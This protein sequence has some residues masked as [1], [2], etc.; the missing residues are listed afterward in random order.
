MTSP[1]SNNSQDV[2]NAF[3]VTHHRTAVV[4]GVK[5]FYREAGPADGETVVL[6][7]GFPTSSH[8]F[9]NLIPALADRYRVIAPDYPGYGQSD[10]PAHSDFAY[11]FDR[12]SLLVD[13]L[14]EQLGA[15]KYAMYVMD[16]GAP[17]GWRIAL[18]HPERV[19]GFI[20]QNGNAY[21]EGLKEFWDPIKQ[22]WNDE[23]DTSRQ[24]LQK[25]L[26]L[27]TTIFQ[28]T[29]GVSD[30]T[31]VAPDNWIHDQALL[32]R[33]GNNDIQLDLFFDYRTNLPLYPTVQAYFREHRP[34]MLIVWGKNDFIFPADGAH[35][36]KRDLPD[37]EFHLIDTGHFALEDKADE[38]IPLIRDFLA[39]KVEQR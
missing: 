3:A 32:D 2:N 18:K 16:Y 22:Y 38:M 25:L 36:Y 14:L 31:R 10:M 4:D 7:H 8:M 33:P 21:E 5:L 15:E 23:S 9:R 17:V 35:P 34:P 1:A 12:I 28:Y 20:V 30:R 11:T 27:D 13:G 24:A 26:T 37:V 19:T 39:R 6:L 29:D